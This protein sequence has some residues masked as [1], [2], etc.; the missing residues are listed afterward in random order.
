VAHRHFPAPRRETTETVHDLLDKVGLAP[1]HADRYPG[2]L[3][4]GQRQRVAI[5]RALATRPRLVVCDEPVSALD[6]STQSQILNLLADLRESLGLGYL[7]ISHD[8]AVVRQVADVVAVMYRGR[9]VEHGPSEA[10]YTRA[11]HPYTQML[12]DSLP[13]PDPT[14]R[15]A[16]RAARA[17]LQATA[18]GVAQPMS[19]GCPFADRCAA[20]MPVCR[21]EFPAATE[22]PDG[23]VV[24]CHLYPPRDPGSVGS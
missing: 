19:A 24:S 23:H 2:Q 18:Q 20:A 7:F 10:I 22:L 9:I 14:R 21:S 1:Y 12:L 13:T 17:Q 3:S 8:L 5:A 6:V 4:G 11:A 15:A 16:R